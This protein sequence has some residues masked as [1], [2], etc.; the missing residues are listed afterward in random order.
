MFRIKN[1]EQKGL[2]FHTDKDYNVR[3]GKPSKECPTIVVDGDK[4]WVE[5]KNGKV[6][7]NLKF[8]S[9]QRFCAFCDANMIVAHL[10][11]RGIPV[12][13]ENN[14]KAIIFSAVDDKITLLGEVPN[15]ELLKK[16]I[17]RA[18][19]CIIVVQIDEKSLEP[20]KVA[21]T[22]TASMVGSVD[23][24]NYGNEIE[25]LGES[26]LAAIHEAYDNFGDH[27]VYW[28]KEQANL[29]FKL[30]GN[31]SLEEFRDALGLTGD[32]IPCV[33]KADED[34]YRILVEVQSPIVDKIYERI[35]EEKD[36]VLRDL[37]V[38]SRKEKTEASID[39]LLG[40]LI[41]QGEKF[42]FADTED[43][44]FVCQIRDNGDVKLFGYWNR[45]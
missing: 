6:D 18:A 36:R 2:D 35:N 41:K 4:Y 30:P 20:F 31:A 45:L 1:L 10:P 29:C 19:F 9:L 38:P 28:Q 25:H 3:L 24:F 11:T 33:K 43:K 14:D 13:V 21:W 12:Y 22:D 26:I 44:A 27:G 5:T 8:Q 16:E 17:V 34:D 7:F 37:P 40:G 42:M 32:E 23:N 39:K 15:N